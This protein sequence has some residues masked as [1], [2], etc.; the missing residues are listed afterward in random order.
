[1]KD[2]LEEGHFD[3]NGTYIWNKRDAS[4][5]KDSWL[6]SIDWMKVSLR[7]HLNNLQC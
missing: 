3:S 5:V 4:E 2:E 7:V 6:D 1:M